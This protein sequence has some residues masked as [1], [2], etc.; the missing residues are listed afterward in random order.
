[1]LKILILVIFF[2]VLALFQTSFLIHFAFFS[3]KIV[4]YS[5][6]LILIIFLNLFTSDHEWHGLGATFAAGFFWD[7][8][9]GSF[10]GFH[11]LIF[12]GLAI[13]IKL[14]LK[15]YVR[16]PFVKTA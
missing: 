13:F 5:L 11:I 4:S 16:V 2:Y 15:K 9:S 12:I 1:M 6:I 10:I 7:V 3:S 14:I 8:F